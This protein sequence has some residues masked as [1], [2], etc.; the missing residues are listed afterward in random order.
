MIKVGN[1]VVEG[2]STPAFRI[3]PT[4]PA[5]VSYVTANQVF[6]AGGKETQVRVRVD[7]SGSAPVYVAFYKF[8]GTKVYEMPMINVTSSSYSLKVF[9]SDRPIA[10][11]ADFFIVANF[12]NTQTILV[13]KVTMID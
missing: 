13:E 5:A 6:F 3:G 8:D 4:T 10:Q 9:T 12:S 2:T 1:V 11:L 7:G